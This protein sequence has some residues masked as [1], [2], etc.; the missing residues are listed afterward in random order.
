MLSCWLTLIFCYIVHQILKHLILIYYYF[1]GFFFLLFRAT[2]VV[3]G[4][5]QARGWIG[6]TAAWPTPQAQQREIQAVSVTYTT[7]HSNAG[8]LTYW[9]GPGIESESSWLLVRFITAEPRRELLFLD[10]YSNL[11]RCGEKL[12]LSLLI[13]RN[14]GSEK[15]LE[16]RLWKEV[17]F[18]S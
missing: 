12:L 15:L 1:L 2:P 18:S 13:R 10:F 16:L 11:L 8:S 9:A 14:W 6:A 3:Y 7:A 17:G 5:S 4:S